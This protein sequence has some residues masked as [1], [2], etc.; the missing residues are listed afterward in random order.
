MVFLRLFFKSEVS[1]QQIFYGQM[2][3]KRTCWLC[4]SVLNMVYFAIENR[5]GCVRY[6]WALLPHL[7]DCEIKFI[8][9]I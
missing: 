4:T 9:E 2:H 8:T 3:Q 5:S 1:A 7:A 6:F